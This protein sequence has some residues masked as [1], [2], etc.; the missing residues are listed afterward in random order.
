MC[1]IKPQSMQS[2]QTK[3]LLCEK[4]G[5]DNRQFSNLKTAISA[6]KGEKTKEKK[7]KLLLLFIFFFGFASAFLNALK[8]S[9]QSFKPVIPLVP[10]L[11]HSCHCNLYHM[12]FG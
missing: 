2:T 7:P 3:G 10:Y 12:A 11:S 8:K 5:R 1:A 6:L 4:G 9:F